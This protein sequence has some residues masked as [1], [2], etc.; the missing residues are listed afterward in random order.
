MAPSLPRRRIVAAFA[1]GAALALA[2]CGFQLRGAQPLGFS[3]IYLGM[4]TQ[5]DLGAAL[6][7]RVLAN[8]TTDV[9]DDPKDAE[10]NLQI[11]QNRQDR[12][13]LTLSGAG[14][15][16]EYELR[17]VIGFRLVDRAGNERIPATTI[18]AKREY[19]Y[20]DRQVLAKEQEEILLFR[21]MQA[22][23]VDQ[24]MRRLAAAK[25]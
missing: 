25:S 6:R 13:I 3:S 9:V 12:E 2:G 23:L 10:V 18:S 22:D 17:H 11:L 1:G 20:D 19:T 16:R 14:K 8:G 4:S 15:V 21:D 7:R 5:S 24:L